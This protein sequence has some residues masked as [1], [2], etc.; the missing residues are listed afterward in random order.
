MRH[1]SEQG[2]LADMRRVFLDTNIVVYANDRRDAKKQQR[3]IEVVSKAMR[4]STGV[5]STQVLQEYAAVA[6][7]RLGQSETATLR[8]LELLE[9]LSVVVLQPAMVRRAVEIAGRYQ[10]SHWDGAIIAAAEHA[11][12]DAVLSEDL[13]AGQAYAGVPIK[14]PFD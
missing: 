13:N 4:T 8:Q 5:I 1:T 10:I 7:T 11:R 9:S 3:A 6:T 12:C 2:S 14:N